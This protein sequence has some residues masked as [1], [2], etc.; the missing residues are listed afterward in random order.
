MVFSGSSLCLKSLRQCQTLLSI[1][2]KNSSQVALAAAD[3]AFPQ[4]LEKWLPPTPL[5][6]NALANNIWDLCPPKS[7]HSTLGHPKSISA[8]FPLLCG[9][10]N[11][12]S[13]SI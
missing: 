9:V 11:I 4:H 13:M 10:D 2:Y 12:Q 6:K 5:I 7:L 3:I 1:L 8:L